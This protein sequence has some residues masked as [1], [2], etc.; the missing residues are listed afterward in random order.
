MGP[1]GLQIVIAIWKLGEPYIYR[2]DMAR[3]KFGLVWFGLCVFVCHQSRPDLGTNEP[4]KLKGLEFNP[5]YWLN[6]PIVSERP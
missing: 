5:I 1:T 3:V 4:N 2:D 6:S